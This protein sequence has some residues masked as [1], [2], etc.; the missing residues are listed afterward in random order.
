MPEVHL[1]PYQAQDLH[2]IVMLWYQTW[3]ATFPDLEHPDPLPLWRHRFVNE[4]LPRGAVWVA[5]HDE[6]II[7]FIV[8]DVEANYLDQIFVERT[9]HGQGIATALLNQAKTL[10]P[11]ELTLHT[12]QNNV[13]ACAF[14][15]REGF[16]AGQRGLNPVNGQPNIAY[17]WSSER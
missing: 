11:T 2:A 4:F 10:C 5:V 16:R 13:R 15:E 12:L 17:H 3:H 7:G 6:R 9:Y 14:Y 1:R 8:V